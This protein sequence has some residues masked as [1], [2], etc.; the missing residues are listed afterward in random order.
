MM[1]NEEDSLGNAFEHACE[2]FAKNYEQFARFANLFAPFC[3]PVHILRTVR[4]FLTELATMFS[5]TRNANITLNL[6]I[7][8]CSNGV[9]LR[10]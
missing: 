4:I 5:Y 10:M 6:I 1:T 9:S 8:L 2:Q 3:E 7:N